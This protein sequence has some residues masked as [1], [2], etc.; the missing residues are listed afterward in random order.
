MPKKASKI[1]LYYY[2]Y[3][4]RDESRNLEIGP[5]AQI[6]PNFERLNIVADYNS[7]Y[8]GDAKDLSI[9]QS[10][11]FELIY[12]SHVLEH[13]PWY[14]S[15]KTLREWCRILKKNGVLEV[16]VPDSLKIAQ[17][18]LDAYHGINNDFMKDGWYRYNKNKDPNIWYAGRTYAYGDGTGSVYNHNWH[19]AAFSDVYLKKLLIQAGFTSVERLDETAVRGHKHGWINLG[20]RAIK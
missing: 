17:A 8:V 9:F 4:K 1:R 2:R 6:I 18:Y 12:A 15:L 7:D 14:E 19:R 5:G 10:G 16:W 11:E 13:I 20:F 3:F